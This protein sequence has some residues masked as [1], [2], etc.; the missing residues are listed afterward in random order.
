[1]KKKTVITTEKRE[2]WVIRRGAETNDQ[3]ADE[4]F[5]AATELLSLLP[6]HS[7]S[8]QIDTGALVNQV[9]QEG[10]EQ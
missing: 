9:T 6:E 7:A 10:E 4:E 3:A 5:K 1:M 8:D 2:V